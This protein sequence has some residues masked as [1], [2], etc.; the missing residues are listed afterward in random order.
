MASPCWSS[1]SIWTCTPD[2]P[3]WDL[4][5]DGHT[6]R[7]RVDGVPN[8][9]AE[10]R[11]DT[12]PVAHFGNVSGGFV[13]V[14]ISAL[15]AVPYVLKAPPGVVIPEVFGAYRWPGAAAIG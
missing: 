9:A 12:D 1:R 4:A 7:I 6:V 10:V 11:V 15:R 13:A 8:I 2:I 3:D 14:G 5:L